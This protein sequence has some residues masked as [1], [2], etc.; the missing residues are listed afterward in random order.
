MP[1][2]EPIHTPRLVL[3]PLRHED[4]AAHAELFSQPQVLRFLY[5][6]EM[7]DEALRLHFDKR[8]LTDLPAEGEWRNLAVLYD[9]QFIGEVGIGLISAVHQCVEIGYVFDPRFSGQGLATEAAEALL[10][11]AFKELNAHRVVARLDARNQASA[12][13]ALRLG[14]RLEAHFR[15]NEW[16]KGEW[17]DEQVFALLRTEW[18]EG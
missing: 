6:E 8:L 9:D 4:Y 3:R 18:V 10:P 11:I 13:L 5:E 17:T 7:D 16:V 1:L 14:M 15:E 12:R 2:T